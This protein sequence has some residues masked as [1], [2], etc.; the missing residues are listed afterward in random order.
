MSDEF[1]DLKAAMTAATPEPDAARR[2]ANLALAEENFARTQGLPDQRRPMSERGPLARLGHG[3]KTMLNV[4]TT[5]G[6]LTLTTGLVAVG[7]VM[8][9]RR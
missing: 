3:V 8:V 9:L 1:D 4:M 6:G 5:R 2:A 7:L